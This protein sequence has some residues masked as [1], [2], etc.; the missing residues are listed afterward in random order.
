[1][2]PAEIVASLKELC[3]E[4]G[5]RLTTEQ[6]VEW[7]EGVGGYPSHRELV[8]FA[9]KMKARQYARR[10]EFEDEET[11]LRIKRLWSFYDARTSRRYYVDIAAMPA[12]RRATLIR[13]YARFLKQLRSVRRAMSDYFAGQRFFDF[14]PG[15]AD[16]EAPARDSQESSRL[17]QQS[18]R[19]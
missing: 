11:G 18:S 17:Q 7:I 14:Y 19:T 15:D 8:H 2:G 6:I 16:A 9:K 4:R 1:M 13:Q 5:P 3:A 12:D 10:L